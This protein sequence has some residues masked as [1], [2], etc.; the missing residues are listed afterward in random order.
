[1]EVKS[2]GFSIF[3][4]VIPEPEESRGTIQIFQ[5]RTGYSGRLPS[6]LGRCYA[7]LLLVFALF[8]GVGDLAHLVGLEK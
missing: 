2:R 1:M 6:D 5:V 7:D 4:E 3:I 8:V